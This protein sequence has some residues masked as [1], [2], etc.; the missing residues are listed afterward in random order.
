MIVETRAR[1]LVKAATYRLAGSL[2]TFAIVYWGTGRLTLSLGAG[3]LDVV[4]K[5]V[6]YF[7]HERAWNLADFGRREIRPGVLWLTGLSGS[8]KTTL[9]RRVHTALAGRGFKAELLDGDT[10]RDLFPST[11]FTKAERDMHVRRV[12]HL[13]SS[14]ERHGVFVVA[15]LVSP[16][17]ASRDFVR[18]LCR[19]FVE[20]HVSTPLE[21]C[22]KR[23]PKGLYAKAR[24]GEI[25]NF[26]GVD[27]PYEP[28]TRAELVIDAARL[29]EDAAF[30]AVMAY[31][32][33]RFLDGRS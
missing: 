15:S 9:A 2:V 13:A 10:I 8:G 20:I 21:I 24:R 19:R 33:A 11:G 22:E 1:S 27:D 7:A 18:G 32:D 3:G 25:E 12:G 26:T 14:L 5:A 31:V 16:Y 6:L 4:A 28:P 29:G 23:D 30:D 17:A